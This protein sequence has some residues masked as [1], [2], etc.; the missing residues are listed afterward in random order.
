MC[1]CEVSQD[2]NDNEGASPTRRLWAVRTL[3]SA[4]N[5]FGCGHWP[6]YMTNGQ[7][8][9]FSQRIVDDVGVGNEAT[10][11]SIRSSRK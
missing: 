1:V 6:R 9:V 5:S 7:F 10:D 4:D 8:L 11:P 2:V 3:L